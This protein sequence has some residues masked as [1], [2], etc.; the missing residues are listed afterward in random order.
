MITA[1]LT[2][3]G[4]GM[5][6]EGLSVLEY[7]EDPKELDAAASDC[8]EN[9][10]EM[11]STPKCKKMWKARGLTSYANS[12]FGQCI[13]ANTNTLYED[14]DRTVDQDCIDRIERDHEDTEGLSLIEYLKNPQELDR[15]KGICGTSWR[16]IASTP[17]CKKVKQAFDLTHHITEAFGECV[18]SDGRRI[19]LNHDKNRTVDADCVDKVAR[20]Q[21]LN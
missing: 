4:C 11:R 7:V 17:R 21:G 1:V 3:T 19:F 9:I 10:D 2:L 20:K 16:D 5:D 14:E 12:L 18:I 13:T 8:K 6:T 15:T